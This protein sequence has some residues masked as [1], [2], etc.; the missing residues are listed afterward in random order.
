MMQHFGELT[1]RTYHTVDYFGAEDA[2]DVVVLMGSGS[3]TVVEVAR[4][5][6]A[7]P[8]ADVEGGKLKGGKYGVIKI[9]LYRPFPV[10]DFVKAIPKTCKRLCIL[11]RIK[12]TTAAGEPLYLDCLA[13]LHANADDDAEGPASL[14]FL[15]RLHVFNG[16]FGVGGTEFN[17]LHAL[18]VYANMRAVKPL[19]R[20]CV[21]IDDDV[22]HTSLA[23]A[24]TPVSTVAAGTVQAKFLGLGSDGTVSSCK[25][26]TT[27]IGENTPLFTQSYTVY[28]AKKTGGFTFSHLRFGREPLLSEYEIYDGDYV[29]CH[30]H[31]FLQKFN[32]CESLKTGGIFVLNSPWESAAD[33]EANLPPYFKK[34]LALKKASFYTINAYAVAAQAGL[35]GLINMILIVCFFADRKSVV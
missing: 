10:E 26:A 22:A 15:A 12:T 24:R 4:H 2:E 19:R 27:L 5:L 11:D 20:F 35:G 28:D 34:D 21:G 1:G 9:R 13:A 18:A 14:S 30:H 3:N 29:A 6:N 31:S 32:V 7:N 25:A 16:K 33:I 8:D 17:P 23:I